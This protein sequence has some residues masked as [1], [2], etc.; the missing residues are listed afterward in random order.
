MVPQ[1]ALAEAQV[2][3]VHMGAPQTP[4]VPAPP[5]VCGAVQVP[6]FC[7]PPQPSPETPQDR[8]S[9]AQFFG[10][11]AAVPHLPGP[12]PPQ[13]AGAVQVPQLMTPPQPS[14]C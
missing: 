11:Q 8:P 4:G 13:M 12:P 3:G 10:V 9:A 1:S 14:A 5:Q 7:V 6:Q 2:R